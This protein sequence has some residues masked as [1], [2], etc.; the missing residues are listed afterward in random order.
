MTHSPLTTE[1]TLVGT[2]QYMA[3]EQL[4]GKEADARSDIFALGCVL[5]EMSTGKRAFDGKSAASVVASIMNTE[6]AP[7][8][9]VAPLAPPALEWAVKKCLA[10]DPDE[11]WQNA[12]DLASELRWIQEGGSR[13]GAVVPSVVRTRR[14]FLRWAALTAA[15][16]AGSLL[17]FFMKKALIQP[18]LRVA[19][20]LPSGTALVPFG[21]TVLSPDG[22]RMVM[23]LADAQGKTKFWVRQLSNDTALPLDGTEGGIYPFWSPDSRFIA[24]FA[25]DG[26]IRK[27]EAGG[28]PAEALCDIWQIYGGA[29][30]RND[31][32]VF[33]TGSKGLYRVPASGG[34]AV[35]IPTP[36]KDGSDYRWPSF[37]PDGK[38]ILVT[39]NA[40]SGGIFV[41]AVD[42]GEVQPVLPSES[43]PAQY[44]EPGYLM[45]LQGDSLMAQP[46]DLRTLRVSGAA[47]RVAESIYN[48]VMTFSTAHSGLLLY[49][50]AFQTQL[51]WFDSEGNKLSTVGDPGYVASP[52]ISPNG[53]YA[54]VTV[55]DPR[56]G[57]QKLWLYDL[58][59]GT[60]TPFT[61]GEGNDQYPAWSPDGQQVAFSSTRG[62]Q[63][64]IYV[65]GV[66]GGSQEQ[67]LLAD[68]GSKE[69]DQW[70]SDGKFILFDYIG[71]KNTGTDVWALPLFGDRKPFP[72]VQG[73]AN[74]NWGAFSPDA[75]WVSYSSD[76][77][78]RAENYVVPFPGPGGKWQIS[79]TGGI[80]SFWVSGNQLFYVT[81]DTH[82]IA[83]GLDIQG[84]N[85]VVGKS[86]VILSGRA[87][88]ISS[89]FNVTRDGKRWLV[90][91]PVAEPNASPLILTTNWTATLNH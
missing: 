22:Q 80:N 7:L 3:P 17:G 65:K 52:Y 36:E 9:S 55:T 46:F 30:G 60:S 33:A 81:P 83:V 76:E 59:R 14:R 89:S 20:N 87:L 84:T 32:I 91:L 5:Y 44:A 73:S 27:M 8:T 51:T 1:G 28:G 72:V 48:G 25:L 79:T 43:S 82:I 31:A 88:V 45:F 38:H 61:F 53:K 63:E 70:S 2:F 12:G 66:A 11:R 54:M 23:T 16:V 50:R 68:P 21:G 29:W 24:F 77:S 39:S 86:R 64:D 49:Q 71:R 85:L 4:E 15:V 10:K 67:L 19:I 18:T 58:S 78:G 34:T 13:A 6:P 40:A 69:P 62:G 75:K 37:L 26:K 57:K 56:Q 47:R 35:R 41:V 74:E 42:T 90:A